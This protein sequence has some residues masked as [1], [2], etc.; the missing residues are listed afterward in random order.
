[1]LSR[2]LTCAVHVLFPSQVDAFANKTGKFAIKGYP[3][4]LGFLL[5]GPP[6]VQ[7]STHVL[8]KH[9]LLQP[10]PASAACAVLQCMHRCD[11]NIV[12]RCPQ[13]AKV[14]TWA[15]PGTA[16]ENMCKYPMVAP[17]V[18]TLPLCECA[19]HMRKPDW[20]ALLFA[21]PAPWL[22][23]YLYCTLHRYLMSAAN[24]AVVQ[25]PARPHSCVPLPPTP[26]APSST[27]LFP[28]SEPTSN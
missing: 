27:S 6:G 9:S 12:H 25:V 17:L 24:C 14:Q 1:M 18:L 3:N 11:S 22:S 4:K 5:H 15:L 16:G 13:R 2:V 21:W 8:H 19:C 28:A 20:L 7:A 26:S 23:R 10:L